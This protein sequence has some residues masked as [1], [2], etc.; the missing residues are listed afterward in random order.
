MAQDQKSYNPDPDVRRLV[1]INA[2]ESDRETALRL[3]LSGFDDTS[4]AVREEDAIFHQPNG[5]FP[6]MAA[7]KLGFKKEQWQDG[8]LSPT[9]G[10]TYS[11]ASPIGLSAVLDKAK[12]GDTILMVSFGSGAASDAFIFQVTEQILKVQD[13]APKTQIQLD[14]NKKYLDYGTYAKFRGKILE[15]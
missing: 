5:K 13:K 1:I 14:T 15:A 11:G 12:P 8:R 2:I 3:I 7:Q 4:S 9:L 10:N 6:M